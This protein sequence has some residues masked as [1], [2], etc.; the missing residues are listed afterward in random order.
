M[1]AAM[2]CANL[3]SA[4]A[5]TSVPRTE[6]NTGFVQDENPEWSATH[7]TAP[8]N[9]ADHR[10]YHRDAEAARTAWLTENASE[11]GTSEYNV[12]FREMMRERNA[13]HRAYHAQF[14]EKTVKPV[15]TKG[16]GEQVKCVFYGSTTEQECY[17]AVDGSEGVS[18]SCKGTT[19]CNVADVKGVKDATLTWKSSCGG[20][21]YTTN[22]G[23]DE[24][25][26]F[27][28][29]NSNTLDMTKQ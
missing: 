14:R 7:E 22:D 27:D 15:A 29:Y 24:H 16:M 28:C 9:A 3:P 26:D 18:Y 23:E 25:A 8:S 11:R 5:A 1:A 2:L 17:A 21:A 19:T 12:A 20:Y 13:K 6:P 4:V 10:Q